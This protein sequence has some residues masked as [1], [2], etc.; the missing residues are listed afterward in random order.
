MVVSRF[1]LQR[2]S[3]RGWRLFIQQHSRRAEC[4]VKIFYSGTGGHSTIW[5]FFDGKCV[6]GPAL[7]YTSTKVVAHILYCNEVDVCYL[8]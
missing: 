1:H 5:L 6:R 7:R 8:P 4:E 3:W 2:E